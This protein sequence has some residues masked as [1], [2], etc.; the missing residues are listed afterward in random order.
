MQIVDYIQEEV[1]RQGYDT[2]RVDGLWRVV[3]ML[4]AW[5]EAQL[6]CERGI[7]LQIALITT[8]G[9]TIE[10]LRNKN[11]IRQCDVVAETHSCPRPQD[12]QPLLAG[13]IS[14]LFIM[15]PL[16]A[17]TKFELIHPFVDGNGRVGK[18][19]LNWLSGTLEDPI[20]P[21]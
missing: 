14:N 18:I 20:F 19:I 21:P 11:G 2:L 8:W 17:Y 7:P 9:I 4:D 12:V 10:P 13:W 6:C 15:S 5:R 1:Q 16:E 3:W